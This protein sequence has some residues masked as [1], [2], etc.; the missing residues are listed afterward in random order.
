MDNFYYKPRT[1]FSMLQKYGRHHRLV[2]LHR[3]RYPKLLDERRFDDAVEWAR[4]VQA[5]AS[6]RG[7]LH[8]AAEPGASAP[9]PAS[10]RPS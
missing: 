3:R 4:K 6:M 5:A 10:P 7:L 1:T 9:T 2:G 8:R